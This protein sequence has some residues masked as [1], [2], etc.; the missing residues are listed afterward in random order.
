MAYPRDGVTSFGLRNFKA[1]HYLDDI[2]LRPLTVLVGTNNSGKSSILQSLALLK[3]TL[4]SSGSKNALKFDGDLVHLDNFE[5]IISTCDVSKIL[6][7]RF[8]IKS[9]IPGK[10]L[11]HYFPHLGTSVENPQ[12]EF[13]TST[14][15]KIEFS[16]ANGNEV[17]AGFAISTLIPEIMTEDQ[18][19]SIFTGDKFKS[20]N[21]PKFPPLPDGTVAD[22]VHPY[23]EKFIPQGFAIA[24]NNVVLKSTAGGFEVVSIS[25]KKVDAE[26]PIG[27]L[28]LDYIP[29]I[30]NPVRALHG[31]LKNRLAYMGP[32]RAD[33]RPFYPA[34]QDPEIGPR[35]EGAIPYLLHHK[36]DLVSYW[37]TDERAIKRTPMSEALS[38]WLQKMGI[39]SK[40]TIDSVPNVATTA[41]LPSISAPE[42]F[43]NL[44]Q[45]GFGIS[46]ILPVLLLGLKDPQNGILLYEQPEIHLH[47]RL[48]AELGDFF[49]SVAQAGRTVLLETHSDYLVNRLRRRI[50]EDTSG[51]LASL[52]SI[53]F[54]HS[55]TLDNPSSYVEKLSINE[56]GSIQNCPADFFAESADEAYA[57]I[58]ARAEKAKAK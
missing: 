7:Y 33:P 15:I 3:Q 42:K 35:G 46:Q 39:T 51:E 38:F 40:L 27:F 55:G 13:T 9:K 53:L 17:K 52:V 19:V 5:T 22:V 4:L 45:V 56:D 34:S 25:E 12:R 24:P 44:A 49:L 18:A 10:Q 29:S 50:A 47:P 14:D 37:S 54:V 28:P 32:V 58:H 43:I 21:V 36:S 8:N 11:S 2:E 6:E 16:K 48:Q 23:G 31:A 26:I 57:I 1:F 41:R 30:S 20:Q